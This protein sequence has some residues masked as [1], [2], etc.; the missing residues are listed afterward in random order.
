MMI[1]ESILISDSFDEIAVKVLDEPR[2]FVNL[3]PDLTL[4]TV[5][6]RN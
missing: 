6:K 2:V 5:K 4:R 3:K 1:L